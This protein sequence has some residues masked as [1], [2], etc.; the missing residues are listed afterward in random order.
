MPLTQV[1]PVEPVQRWPH[2]PQ[3]AGSVARVTHVDP[4]Q[5]MPPVQGG[6]QADSMQLEPMQMYPGPQ[7]FPHHPQFV[8]SEVVST[9]LP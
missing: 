7:L 1:G 4:Q 2:V 6:E 3:F 5:S 9:Q 8:A